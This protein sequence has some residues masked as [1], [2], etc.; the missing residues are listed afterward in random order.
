MQ[1]T[2]SAPAPA[3]GIIST[4]I[5]PAILILSAGNLVTSTFSRLIRVA[6]RARSMIGQLDDA[7]AAGR[8]AEATLYTELLAE[9]RDRSV[10]IERALSSF[11]LAIGLLVMASLAIAV[12][13]LLGDTIAWVPVAF[14]VSGAIV[15][16]IGTMSLFRETRISSGAIR[17]E[18]DLH[19]GK[20]SR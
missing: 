2:P 12:D 13:R 10:L 20:S 11:Y 9:Y 18:I 19:E 17:R 15:L 8:Q 3:L 4:M 1:L 7:R 16:L 5:A 14:T 6:D